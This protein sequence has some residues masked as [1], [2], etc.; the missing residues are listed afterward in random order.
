MLRI[1]GNPAV[2]EHEPRI[3]FH[4]AQHA[5]EVNG[6]GAVMKMAQ[7]LIAD[8]GVDPVVTA[9][10]DGLEQCFVPVVNVD[11]HRHVFSAAPNWQDWRKTLR[12]NDG[13]ETIDFPGDGVDTN[14]NWDWRWQEYD[15]TDPQKDKGPAPWSESE[16]V[17]LRDFILAERPVL[18]VDYHSPVTISW[19][20]AIFWP[21]QS[22]HG[23]GESPDAPVF[24]DISSEWAAATLTHDGDHFSSWWSYDTL[25]KEQ[26]W[27]Y[28]NTGILT[29]VMEISDRCW[30]TGAQVDTVAARV[31]RG[32]EYLQ[33]RVLDGPGIRGR[34]TDGNTGEPLVAEVRILEY[35]QAEIGPHLTE[36]ALGGYFR[37][38]LNGGFTLQ[39]LCDGYVE[40][41]RSVNV[42]GSGWAVEDFQLVPDVV[43]V[44][45]GPEIGDWLRFDN[46]LGL[47]DPIR[48]A[49]PAGRLP[50]RLE[51]YD[52]R[53]RFVAL[54][55]EE[56]AAG[57]THSR[58]LP[59]ELSAGVYL[60]RLRS[61][62]LET[63]DRFTLLR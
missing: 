2:V 29:L 4:G 57:L 35:H 12:D 32:S 15:S 19:T 63:V 58:R 44:D 5:N 11:G 10:V 38:T 6:T 26:C 47:G 56:M 54:L 61:G 21:W 7:R 41:Q 53:G 37:L 18:V 36:P 3:L 8:Y 17:A 50:A 43:S 20:D 46:P 48:L 40:Q 39:V 34:V 33:G 51:L 22:Q 24:G 62:D 52:V 30:W 55:G 23:L 27:V 60:L 1:S 59:A 31:A 42:G 13:D 16:V 25:P 28:G 45:L 14:R 9:R 49:L